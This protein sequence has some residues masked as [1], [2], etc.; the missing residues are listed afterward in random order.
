MVRNI[1]V[2][3]L[4]LA[5]FGLG[6]ALLGYFGPL[7]TARHPGLAAAGAASFAAYVTY[8]LATRWATFRAFTDD[9]WHWR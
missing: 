7:M 8:V 3:I 5:V 2:G 9:P 6:L 4:F 1:S